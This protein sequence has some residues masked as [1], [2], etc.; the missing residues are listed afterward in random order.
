MK[1]AR[2]EEKTGPL[3]IHKFMTEDVE[4]P[5]TPVS[6]VHYNTRRGCDPELFYVSLCK[7]PFKGEREPDEDRKLVQKFL[8]WASC[9][10]AG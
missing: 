4:H 10:C 3:L 8:H 7:N 9:V 1:R 6:V 2:G 5:L